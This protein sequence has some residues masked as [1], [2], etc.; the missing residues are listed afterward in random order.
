MYACHILARHSAL[1]LGREKNWLAQCQNNVTEWDIRDMVLV[2][3]YPCDAAL[4]NHNDCA[5]A[6]VGTLAR[7]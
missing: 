1:L 2:A 6:Q 7:T 3:L 4:L 5:L